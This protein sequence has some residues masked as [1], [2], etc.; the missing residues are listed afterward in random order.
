MH[1]RGSYKL[2]SGKIRRIETIR[3]MKTTVIPCGQIANDSEEKAIKILN[4]RLQE[5]PGSVAEPRCTTN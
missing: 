5:A 2:L 1:R 3:I 4:H